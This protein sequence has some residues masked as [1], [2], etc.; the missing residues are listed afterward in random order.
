MTTKT[1][2]PIKVA[3]VED[4]PAFRDLMEKILND[5][6]ELKVVAALNNCNQIVPA[7]RE[8]PPQ[9]VLMD[10]QLKGSESGIEGVKI[11]RN[12]FPE[13]RMLMF[14]VFEDDD[15]IFNS[16]CAGACGYLLKN[17]P[18]Q[19]IVKALIELHHGGAPMTP[20]IANRALQLFREKISPSQKENSLSARE[21]EILQCL[22]EGHTYQKIADKLFISLST[23]RTHIMHIYEKLEV[24]SKIEAIKKASGL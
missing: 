15:K 10:I 3:I 14:T 9:I 13:I 17:T 12:Y 8:N 1:Q 23:V 22:S 7:F 24:N 11:V 4:N 21:R 2:F 20:S 18:P 16:I 6:G 19:D 5:S